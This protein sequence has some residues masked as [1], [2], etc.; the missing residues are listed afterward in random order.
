MN[1]QPEFNHKLETLKKACVD[2]GMRL[3][4]QRTEI[5]REL[6]TAKDHPSA[7]TLYSRVKIKVPAISLDTVYRTLATFLECGLAIKVP[8]DMDQSRFDGNVTPHHHMLC[9]RCGRIGDFDWPEV[10]TAHLP[11]E[12]EQWGAVVDTQVIV[13][14]VCRHCEP[15]N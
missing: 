11:P 5:L 9:M 8:A 7:E 10:D 1:Q 15:K 4:H 13:R 6:S 3:T 2:K 12:L 14:G